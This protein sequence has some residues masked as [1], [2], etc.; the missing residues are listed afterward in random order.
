MTRKVRLIALLLTFILLAGGL[1]TC[2]FG[3]RN[4][5]KQKENA[6]KSTE[7]SGSAQNDEAGDDY[8]ETLE[9][10]EDASYDSK[11]EVCAY[12]VQFHKLPSNYMSKKEARNQ[13]WEGGALS[14]LIPG[15]CIGGDFFGNNEGLLPEKD[16][17]E[18]HECDIDTLGRSGRGAKRIIYS[19]DDDAG[20]WNIYYT[21]DHYES[22]SL[23]WG[24]DK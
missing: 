23:L 22:F 12:L 6:V 9:L 11:D 15:R 17:R 19:G 10:D 4:K 18:Y 5:N 2:A 7:Q 13:G 3:K 21:D 8:Y 1:Q 20:E 14:Q 16:G 24:N